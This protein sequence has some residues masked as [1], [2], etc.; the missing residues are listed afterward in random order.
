MGL[1]S[2]GVVLGPVL[3]RRR[4]SIFRML[5]VLAGVA[6]GVALAEPTP[7]TLAVA[8]EPALTQCPD[9]R[10]IRNAVAARL[11]VDPFRDEATLAVKVAIAQAAKGML[12][13]SLSVVFPDGRTA[14]RTLRSADCLELASAL[15]LAI[16][17]VI[18]PRAPT[19]PTA[20]VKPVA[21]PPPE[22]KPEPPAPVP[23]PVVVVQV[24]PPPPE[25]SG[26]EV[27]LGLSAVA[28]GGALPGV[29]LGF[30]L[31]GRLRWGLGSLGLEGRVHLPASVRFDLG[32]V[33][34]FGAHG[35][36]TPCVHWRGAAVCALVS[37]G[38]VQ[39]TGPVGAQAQQTAVRVGVG[40]RLS[41]GFELGALFALRPFAEVEALLSRLTIADGPRVV[42]VTWPLVV[43]GG[44][45]FEL[46]IP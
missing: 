33:R 3:T 29:G 31:F 9:A 16:A 42:W 14:G 46:R 4:P 5:S 32:D 26:P 27:A 34:L 17:L 8:V 19:Q 11:G 13:A 44:L 1:S 21:P 2:V 38:A 39:V 37:V 41:W 6:W 45:A 7:A 36:L 28:S 40:S 18:E 35:A 43:S 20:E 22:P 15:E 23:T 24:A 10:W 25:P 30:G 12:E